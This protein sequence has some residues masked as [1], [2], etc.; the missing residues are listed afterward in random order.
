MPLASHLKE[1]P[2]KIIQIPLVSQT[3]VQM[4]PY[5]TSEILVLVHQQMEVVIL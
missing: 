1:H 4:A 5:G 2:L 3:L